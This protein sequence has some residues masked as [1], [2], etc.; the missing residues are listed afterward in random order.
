MKGDPTDVYHD[1]IIGKGKIRRVRWWNAW[2]WRYV[3]HVPV[4]PPI[5]W[6][7]VERYIMPR[8]TDDA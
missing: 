2:Y 7:G 3:R 4:F 8:I 1:Y 5:K 6:D